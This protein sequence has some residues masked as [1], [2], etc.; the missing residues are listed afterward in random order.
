MAVGNE[1]RLASR[2]SQLSLQS[3]S[4]LLLVCLLS[5]LLDPSIRNGITPGERKVG[6]S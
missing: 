2:T 4:Q 3:L 5:L 6:V 1:A